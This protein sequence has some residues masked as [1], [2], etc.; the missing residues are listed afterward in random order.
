MTRARRE[1]S[2]TDAPPR[3]PARCYLAFAMAFSLLMA[4]LGAVWEQ[5][6]V[7]GAGLAC[8]GL[9]CLQGAC[10]HCAGNIVVHN[11]VVD[12]PDRPDRP[13]ERPTL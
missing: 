5:Q 12:R 3:S 1:A 11:A 13:L 7:F 2:S 4:L 6:A 9:L 10:G 8:F